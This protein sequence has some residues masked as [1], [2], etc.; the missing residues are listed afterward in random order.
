MDRRRLISR[1][2]SI[3]AWAGAAFV[4]TQLAAGATFDAFG[5]ARSRFPELEPCLAPLRK[6]SRPP[7]VICLGSSRFM[8]CL[9][10]SELTAELR[11]RTGRTEL[12]AF[13]ATVMRADFL[14]QERI[15]QQLRDEHRMPPVLILEV[16]PISVRWGDRWYDTYIS[17][18][19]RWQDLPEHALE[20]LRT[21]QLGRCCIER[22]IPLYAHRR[23][24]LDLLC[25][26]QNVPYDLDAT[27][28]LDE[29]TMSRILATPPTPEETARAALGIIAVRNDLRGFKVGGSMT[30]ALERMLDDCRSH[31]VRVVLVGSPVSSAY[32]Q[33]VSPEIDAAYRGYLASIRERFDVPFVDCHAALPDSLF[34][35]HHHITSVGG[36]VFSRL[37]VR[38]LLAPLFEEPSRPASQVVPASVA[39]WSRDRT[40]LEKCETP[41]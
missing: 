34:K 33:E 6:E 12:T 40:V 25:G 26:R 4:L 7:D 21:G 16:A 24:I 2:R 38:N 22:L 9:N 13:K 37:L 36:Q 29:A 19:L 31:G 35:D 15:V 28:P 27:E 30:R 41:P 11:R 23:T 8:T 1:P 17:R 3:L 39:S 10:S 20:I 5:S 18:L 32:R 14:V